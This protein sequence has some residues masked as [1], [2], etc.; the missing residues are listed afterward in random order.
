MICED[1][2]ACDK[3]DT[4]ACWMIWLRESAAVSVAK[5]ASRMRPREAERFSEVVERLL[6]VDSSLLWSA[7]S[8]A[9][10]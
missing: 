1:W 9:R 4:P 8:C 3:I 6:M 10:W 7:P 5:S 2:F